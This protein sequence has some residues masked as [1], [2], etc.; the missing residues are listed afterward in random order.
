MRT[1]G[2]IGGG[3]GQAQAALDHGI[4]AAHLDQQ[5]GQGGGTQSLEIVGIEGALAGH[6]LRGR[7]WAGYIDARQAARITP[8]S[9]PPKLHSVGVGCGRCLRGGIGIAQQGIHPGVETG[10]PLV[11]LPEPLGFFL[12]LLGFV[13]DL[14]GFDLQLL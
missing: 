1:D 2:A 8:P 13:P 11:L 3:Q 4:A 12:D 9:A 5:L 6:R 10:E 7:V 14:L